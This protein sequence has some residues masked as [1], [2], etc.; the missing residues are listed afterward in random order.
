MWEQRWN[1]SADHLLRFEHGDA[2]D[3]AV[4]LADDV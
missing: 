4:D 1:E 3:L 2:V